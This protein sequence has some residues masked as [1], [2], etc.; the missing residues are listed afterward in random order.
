M[1]EREKEEMAF[2]GNPRGQSSIR[3]YR[4]RTLIIAK[5]VRKWIYIIDGI[6]FSDI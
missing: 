6:T 2:P 4:N 5:Y 1:K 3:K